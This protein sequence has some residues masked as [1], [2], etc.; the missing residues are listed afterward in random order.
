MK[1]ETVR[2]H[3]LNDVF[4]LLASKNFAMMAIGHYFFCTLDGNVTLLLLLSIKVVCL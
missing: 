2:I 1:F 3:F 4:G